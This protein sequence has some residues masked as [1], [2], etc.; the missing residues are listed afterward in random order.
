MITIPISRPYHLIPAQV[1][2]YM[3]KI[4]ID[5]FFESGKLR[6]SSFKTYKNYEDNVK[7]DKGE[8][9]NIAW[10]TSKKEEMTM[11]AVVGVGFDAYSLCASTLYSDELK[12][13]FNCNAAFRIK[14][15]HNFGIAIANKV[16]GF[17]EGMQGHCIYVNRRT[18]TRELESFSLDE[19]RIAPDREEFDMGKMFNKIR[20]ANPV[21]SFFMK[22]L[23][24]QYQSEYRFIWM[25]H[26]ESD[27]YI[28]IECK[29]AVQFCE[30]IE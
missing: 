19:M 29:E 3:D 5:Q 10:A 24:Y 21:D 23:S 12:E 11:V 1:Y 6:L 7:G 9:R 16:P 18:T 28:E 27:V 15:S 25:V 2:R 13:K 8:G 30:K 20:E 14:D 4:Y 22:P 17:I 26:K